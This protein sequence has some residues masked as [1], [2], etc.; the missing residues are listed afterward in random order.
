MQYKNGKTIRSIHTLIEWIN[1][2]KVESETEKE[3][4]FP[5]LRSYCI[6]F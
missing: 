6:C 5:F 2:V 3:I 4:L 1:F